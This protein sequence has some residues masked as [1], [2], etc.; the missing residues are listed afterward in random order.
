MIKK[1]KWVKANSHHKK[2]LFVTDLF[3]FCH[4][5][6]SQKAEKREK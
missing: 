4:A 3:F 1:E 2:R 6:F 5:F